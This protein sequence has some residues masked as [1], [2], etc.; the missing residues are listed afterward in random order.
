MDHK[1]VFVLD[2]GPAMLES[3]KYIVDFDIFTK[4]RPQVMTF[5]VVACC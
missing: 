1:T 4:S 3:S 2:H 5:F